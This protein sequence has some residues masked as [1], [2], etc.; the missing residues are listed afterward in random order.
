M[1]LCTM[2]SAWENFYISNKVP[3]KFSKLRYQ[4]SV[5]L[6]VREKRFHLIIICHSSKYYAVAREMRDEMR[7]LMSTQNDD[8]SWEWRASNQAKVEWKEGT[9]GKSFFMY[10]TLIKIFESLEKYQVSVCTSFQ[11]KS[12]PIQEILHAHYHRVDVL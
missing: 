9:E 7:M 2:L 6:R 11:W 1:L 3:L 12:F 10:E 5:W 4:L 8:E